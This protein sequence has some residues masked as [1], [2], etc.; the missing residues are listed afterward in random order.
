MIWNGTDWTV[1][2]S[3]GAALVAKIAHDRQWLQKKDP[4]LAQEIQKAEESLPHGIG[5][6]LDDA[7]KLV[8]GLVESPWFAS[9]AATGKV[10]LHH[11][12]NKLLQSHLDGEIAKVLAASGKAWGDMSETE[13]G[14]LITTVQAGLQKLGV[15][16]TSSQVTAAVNA[17]EEGI[18]AVQPAMQNAAKLAA[19]ITQPATPPAAETAPATTA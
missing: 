14:T 15:T 5:V 12:T 7:G 18:A 9:E 1:V 3:V 6:A 10:E 19:S 4:Q 13:K 8:R 16:V 2:V 17:V 11:I